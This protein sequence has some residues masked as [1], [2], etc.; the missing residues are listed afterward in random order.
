M[1]EYIS[2]AEMR[3]RGYDA[4]TIAA[5]MHGEERREET[6][7]IC[8]VIREAFAGVKLG[9]GVGLMQA[10]GLDDYADDK[11]LAA[12]RAQDEKDDW[13]RIPVEKLNQC[14]S[15]PSFFDAEGMRFHLPAY[16]IADLRGEYGFG[17]TFALT[18]KVDC[19]SRYTLLDPAQRAAV[20]AYLLF[21]ASDDDFGRRDIR[22]AL[23]GYWNEPAP[24]KS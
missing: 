16:L 4:T 18:H 12:Y 10:Q 1:K 15:S 8:E 9:Q 21:M 19:L 7:R 17:M 6:A 14:Y 5:A 24:T 11:T 22:R 20:R 3:A 13:S 23:D 2:I